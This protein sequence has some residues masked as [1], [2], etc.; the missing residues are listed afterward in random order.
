M[1][2][3]KKY[4]PKIREREILKFWEDNKIYKFDKNTKKKIYSIDTPPP[5]VSGRMHI[6]HAFSYTQTDFIA[7]YKRMKGFEVFYPFGTDDNGLATEKLVQKKRKVNLRKVPRDEAIIICLDYLKEETPNFVQDWKNIGVSCDFSIYYSTIDDHSRYIAQ[8]SFL[9]LKEK[10]LIYRKEGPVLWDTV[11]QTAIAQ[12]ELEDLERESKFNDIIFKTEDGEEIV[13]ST[14][15]PELLGACVGIFVNPEDKRYRN[16]VGKKVITP[17]Y[18]DVVPVLE[19]ESVEIDKGTGIMMCCTFGDQ[20]DIEKYKKHNLPLKIIINKDG[21]MNEKAGKYMGMKIEEAREEIL[22]DLEKEGY[23]KSQKIIKQVVNIGE[24]SKKPVEIIVSK[25]WFVKYLDY[26]KDFLVSAEKLKWYPSHMKHRLDNWI[27]GLQ[28]DWNISRQRHYGTPIP[29]WYCKN[30]DTIKYADES[31]LPVDP[32]KDKPLSPCENCNCNEF[33]PET[34]VFDTWFTS[35]SS[36]F[37]AIG[38]IDDL[39]VRKKL[40]PMNLRPQAHDIINFWLFYTMAKT[41][42]LH[43]V[44]PWKIVN[45]SGFVL[46]SKGRKMSKS[47]GNIVVPQEIVEKYSADSLRFAAAGTKLGSDIPFHEKEV[48]TG[49]KLANKLYNAAKFTS[50]L[51]RD[52]KEENRDINYDELKSI[53]KWIL[54][55]LHKVIK[56]A[57]EYFD[58]YDYSKVK[59]LFTNFFMH[60][61]ADDYIEIIKTRLW[62]PDKYKDDTLKAQ[63]TL[64][65][66]LFNVVKGLAPFIPYITEEVY[67]N[68]FKD[69]EKT[70]SIHKCSWPEYN[71]SLMKEDIIEMGNKYV[72][73]VSVVRRFKANKNLSMKA[74]LS[75]LIIDC[76]EELKIFIEDSLEDLKNVTSIKEIIFGK[77][78][79]EKS[80]E[81]KYKDLKIIIEE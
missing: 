73:V 76:S 30:C 67:L 39:K 38:L 13:I 18:N 12:A 51:L 1:V 20:E 26:K 50:M 37:L 35:A 14:T 52:F 63:S 66:V 46:D 8:K 6:G 27:K 28:W 31:Q 60:N 36:P 17:L 70:I 53:D 62:N 25:Q 10:G 59:A 2:F 71:E 78:D 47:L 74:E 43:N 32:F 56:E 79:E 22:K 15:R 33:V 11:F 19:D 54:S 41:N 23:L 65:N 80:L 42:L 3:E 64:Y 75:R 44:N 72:D 5:T 40:F 81:T 7:R 77:V 48:K 29:V 55:S 16:L 45:I 4:N 68:F 61:L 21:T 34:D 58:N 69:Y 24:R 9:D 57:T 49:Y